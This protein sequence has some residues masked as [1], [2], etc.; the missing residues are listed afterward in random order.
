MSFNDN[1]IYLYI[2]WNIGHSNIVTFFKIPI[3]KHSILINNYQAPRVSD[4]HLEIGRLKLLKLLKLELLK[5][6]KLN[7]N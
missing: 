5:L 4:D 7:R 2:P 3:T 1:N 6:L